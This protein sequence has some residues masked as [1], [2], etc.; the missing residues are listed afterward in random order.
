MAM[1][2]N[3]GFLRNE[4]EISNGISRLRNELLSYIYIYSSEMAKMIVQSFCKYV[5]KN[6]FTIIL[7]E[8]SSIHP[9]LIGPSSHY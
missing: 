5:Q 8:E 4:D 1:N 7:D 2:C 6:N 3:T 9:P